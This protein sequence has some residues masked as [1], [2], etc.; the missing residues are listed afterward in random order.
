VAGDEAHKSRVSW[1][2]Y[3]RES[4][5]PGEFRFQ[6]PDDGIDLESVE[7]ELLLYSLRKHNWNQTK[8]AKFLRI[9]RQTLLYRMEKYGLKDE[10]SK[11]A[12][13]AHE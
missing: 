8:A 6:V 5:Q 3:R 7:R 11:S 10:K 12:E 4:R 2:S 13:P 1:A 9:T